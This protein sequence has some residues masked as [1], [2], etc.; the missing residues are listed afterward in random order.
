M[1]AKILEAA[2]HQNLSAVAIV[3]TAK[4]K[5]GKGSKKS[6]MTWTKKVVEK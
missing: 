5:Q 1:N 4:G 3:R 6:K 2:E